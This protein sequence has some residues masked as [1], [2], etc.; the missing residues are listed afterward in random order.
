[1]E[2]EKVTIK[3]STATR[4][5]EWNTTSHRFFWQEIEERSGGNALIKDEELKRK[6][7]YNTLIRGRSYEASLIEKRRR[8]GPP[9]NVTGRR[10]NAVERPT[11]QVQDIRGSLETEG[12]RRSGYHRYPRTRSCRNCESVECGNWRDMQRINR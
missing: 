2:I 10:R 9:R 4:V 1:M 12:W 7:D 5:L 11:V 8:H 6:I 3:D